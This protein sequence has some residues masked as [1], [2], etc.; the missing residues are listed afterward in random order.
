M[1]AKEVRESEC[2]SVME[3]IEGK[4]STRKGAHFGLVFKGERIW[5]IDL[6]EKRK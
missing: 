6:M 5:R 2:L 1:P 4:Y 3:G